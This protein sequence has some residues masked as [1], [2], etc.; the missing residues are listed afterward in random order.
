[1]YICSFGQLVIKHSYQI[2]LSVRAKQLTYVFGLLPLPSYLLAS[3]QEITEFVL[4]VMLGV[5]V[6]IEPF[7]HC[8]AV[9]PR[10]ITNCCAYDEWYCELSNSYDRT[11]TFPMMLYFILAAELIHLNIDLS[12][13][14]IICS[15]LWSDFLVFLGA[16]VFISMAFA[17]TMSCLPQYPGIQL[18]D[19]YNFP[20]SFYSIFSIGLNVYGANNFQ[21]IAVADEHWLM[22][23]VMFFSAVWHVY[24][25]SLIVAQLCQRYNAVH[26]QAMGRARLLRGTLIFETAMPL[27]SKKRWAAFVQALKLDENC[28]LDEGDIG[29]K[30]AVQVLE[31]PE[32]YVS[33]AS[34]A[35]DRVIRFGGLASPSLPW[36]EHGDNDNEDPAVKLERL[37]T[38]RFGQLEQLMTDMASSIA[39]LSRATTGGG[40]GGN[41]DEQ[42][43]EELEYSNPDEMYEEVTEEVS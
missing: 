24:M 28:D 37:V 21:E 7:F 17:S 38:T 18:R 1:M 10:W 12:R 42:S 27:I 8:L 33:H 14:V 5:M 41:S 31:A 32:V 40:A 20:S 4:A 2:S 25:M 36:P 30:G 23:W 35:L 16:L 11:S 39:R 19:Y 43:K 9:S 26:E 15:T 3:R 34:L 13:F 22:F 29:P 6:V